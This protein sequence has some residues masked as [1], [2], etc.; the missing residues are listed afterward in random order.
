MYRNSSGSSST[1]LKIMYTS[2]VL[3]NQIFVISLLKSL[4]PLPRPRSDDII[5]GQPL[6]GIFS[7]KV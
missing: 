5:Y 7:V 1:V 3:F 2:K 6:E 4:P